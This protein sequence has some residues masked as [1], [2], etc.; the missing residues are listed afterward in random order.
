MK[1]DMK[2]LTRSAMFAATA[3]FVSAAGINASLAA[4]EPTAPKTTPKTSNQEKDPDVHVPGAMIRHDSKENADGGTPMDRRQTPVDKVDINDLDTANTREN[5]SEDMKLNPTDQAF[6]KKAM[7]INDGEVAISKLAAEK[8]QN[9]EVKAFAKM[10]AADH[11]AN[12]KALTVIADRNAIAL[13]KDHAPKHEQMLSSL[14]GKQGAE[15]DAVYMAGMVKGHKE[16]VMAFE[17]GIKTTKDPEL[18]T[19]VETTL[20]SLREHLKSAEST[21][22]KVASA[23]TPGSSGK[24]HVH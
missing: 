2:N 7:S 22:S 19:Y 24:T 6:V 9:A 21:Q 3:A 11:D 4:E 8:A 1:L 20:P 12:R 18:K 5:S 16:A 10:M 17:Q 14:K 15:F 23:A 13:D